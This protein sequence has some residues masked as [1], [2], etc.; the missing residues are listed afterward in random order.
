MFKNYLALCLQNRWMF[1]KHYLLIV[2]ESQK[3]VTVPQL[4]TVKNCDY[5]NMYE[6]ITFCNKM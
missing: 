3:H 1:V 6:Y 5:F 2:V 4:D